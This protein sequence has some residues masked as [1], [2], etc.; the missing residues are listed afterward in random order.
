MFFLIF[1]NS[2][3]KTEDNSDPSFV[4][5]NVIYRCVCQPDTLRGLQGREGTVLFLV[6]LLEEIPSV[7]EKCHLISLHK[8]YIPLNTH[9]HTHTN[10]RQAAFAVQMQYKS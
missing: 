9:T 2:I 1:F 8:I 6:L 5:E 7:E 4:P 3:S 10:I